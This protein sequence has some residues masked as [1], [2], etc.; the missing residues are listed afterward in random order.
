MKTENVRG[1]ERLSVRVVD[2]A[3]TRLDTQEEKLEEIIQ[4]ALAN[5]MDRAKVISPEIIVVELSLIH[6]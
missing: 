6:I 4:V 5:G 1:V 3:V 2:E